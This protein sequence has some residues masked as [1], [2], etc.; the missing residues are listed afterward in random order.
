M[1]P[2]GSQPRLRGDGAAGGGIRPPQGVLLSM[3]VGMGR[4][5]RRSPPAGAPIR[6]SGDLG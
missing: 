1:R 3:G 2:R 6:P 4:P 5:R